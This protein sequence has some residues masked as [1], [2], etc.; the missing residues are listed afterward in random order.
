MK[1]LETPG[2]YFCV[3]AYICES[4]SSDAPFFLSSHPA[5]SR[6]AE[7]AVANRTRW[8]L[9]WP[10]ACDIGSLQ[11]PWGF[12]G[13]SFRFSE[14]STLLRLFPNKLGENAPKSPI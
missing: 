1:S 10:A 12:S 6:T 13:V 14:L 7:Q 2:M 4:A 9:R 8:G 5:V 11:S 3:K